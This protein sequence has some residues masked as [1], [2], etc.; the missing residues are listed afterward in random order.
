MLTPVNTYISRLTTALQE[1]NPELVA[2]RGSVIHDAF[3]LPAASALA[4]NSSLLE[5]T[6]AMTALNS[7]L[8][9]K[10]DGELLTSVAEALNLSVDGVTGLLS[11]SIDRIGSNFGLTRKTAQKAFGLVSFYVATAPAADLTV[12]AG[13]VVETATKV[14]FS[15]TSEVKLIQNTAASFYDPIL[16]AYS[17]SAPV[18]ALLAGA[19]STASARTLIYT[20]GPVPSGFEGVINKYDITNGYDAETDEE[21]VARIQATL[22][23]SNLETKDGLT[24]LV[25]N[26]TTARSIF[27][28]DAQSPFQYRNKGK[29]GVADVYMIDVIPAAVVDT[30]VYSGTKQLLPHRPVIGITSVVGPIIGEPT[31]Q[32][33]QGVDYQLTKDTTVLTRESSQAKDYLEWLGATLPIAG[34]N[35]TVEYVYNQAVENVQALV[36]SDQYRPLMG[37][38]S[39]AVLAREGIQVDVAISFQV[40][41]NGGYSRSQVL[42]AAT[43]AVQGYI[44]ALGFGESVAQS[45]IVNVLENVPGVNYVLSDTPLAFNRES[46][47]G[48]TEVIDTAAYEYLRANT[49]TIL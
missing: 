24:A 12:P 31:H 29:G 7:I 47:G 25:L 18:E 39:S 22:R 40:V 5:M 20:T 9:A 38:V 10:Q 43:A 3:I 1:R 2:R 46:V 34:S 14:Q 45:D 36:D 27:V 15:T 41:I 44:N 8:T 33:V 23:G 30:L 21:F 49:V 42:A 6:R 4:W 32:F 13:T 37:D 19:N 48:V 28:A 16:N 26:N 17:V 35:Y 11:E